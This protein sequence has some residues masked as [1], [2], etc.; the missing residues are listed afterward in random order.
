MFD[1]RAIAEIESKIVVSG[2]PFPN[3]IIND[4]LPLEAIKK[5][6]KEFINLKETSSSGS[7]T[8]QNTKKNLENFDSMPITIKK[9]I[10]FL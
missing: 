1:K 9:I 6:E 5:A 4:F 10:K 8:F 2:D 3:A 7:E